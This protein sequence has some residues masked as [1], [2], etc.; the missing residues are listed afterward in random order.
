MSAADRSRTI[1]D[2]SVTSNNINGP[3]YSLV[4]DCPRSLKTKT[5]YPS[6]ALRISVIFGPFL[7]PFA[8]EICLWVKYFDISDVAFSKAFGCCAMPG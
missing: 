4:P 8:S 3:L 7:V 2:L 5:Y 1:D 6:D